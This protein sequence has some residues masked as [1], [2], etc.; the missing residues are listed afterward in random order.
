MKHEI[1]TNMKTC[2]YFVELKLVKDIQQG[3]KKYSK[4]IILAQFVNDK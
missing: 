4:K 2:M 3:A 1:F